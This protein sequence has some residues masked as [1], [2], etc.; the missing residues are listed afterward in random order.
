MMLYN[1]FI[2]IFICFIISNCTTQNLTLNKP[3]VLSNNNFSNKGFAL[4]YQKPLYESKLISSKI[5]ERDL[6][7]FQ[8]N[9]IRGTDVK[10]TNLLNNKSTLAKVGKNSRYPLFN[11]SVLSKRIADEIELN[12]DEPYVEISAIPKNSLFIAKKAK[13]FE[14]EKEVAIKVPVNS[15]SIDD[16]NTKKLIK[17]IKKDNN[18]SYTI[19]VADFYFKDTAELMLKRI[20][21]ETNIKIANIIE[22]SKNI[23]RVNLGPF[24]SINSLQ[25]SYN[26]VIV[27]GFENLEIIKND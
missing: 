6:V 20:N 24:N 18:F 15:I 3:K 14:E 10:I 4:V 21:G 13:T 16:L 22:I 12:I 5:N 27:L 1:R 11:N 9:L 25:N 26:D 8:R 23:H 19:K 2:L 17:K 7:I